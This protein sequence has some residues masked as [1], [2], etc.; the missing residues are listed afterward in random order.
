MKKFL[1]LTALSVGVLSVSMP[2]VVNAALKKSQAQESSGFLKKVFR[3]KKA[4]GTTKST[5]EQSAT[6]MAPND[7]AASEG[8][9]NGT[10]DSTVEPSAP[11]IAP[12]DAAAPATKT[13]GYTLDR[14]DMGKHVILLVTQNTRDTKELKSLIGD[15]N[16]AQSA[17][18]VKQKQKIKTFRSRAMPIDLKDARNVVS[19]SNNVLKG[20]GKNLKTI[21][22]KTFVKEGTSEDVLKNMLKDLEDE[23]ASLKAQI[24]LLQEA[25]ES[26]KSDDQIQKA[27]KEHLSDLDFVADLR[28]EAL[29]ALSLTVKNA[30]LGLISLRS[31][32]KGKDGKLAED[33]FIK[34]ELNWAEVA[35]EYWYFMD[36][37]FTIDK[38]LSP[39]KKDKQLEKLHRLSKVI[40]S[41]SRSGSKIGTEMS[42]ILKQLNKL[43]TREKTTSKSGPKK[44]RIPQLL[45]ILNSS[46]EGTTQASSPAQPPIRG[47]ELGTS[48]NEEEE[49]DADE[50]RSSSKKAAPPAM[51][52][53]PVRIVVRQ[54]KVGDGTSSP[55]EKA[56]RTLFSPRTFS[57]LRKKS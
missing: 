29:V 5:V 24:S 36:N 30:E 11:P 19:S 28:E 17:A 22:E 25:L 35:K 8:A 44:A 46:A 2:S 9:T 23:S 51:G 40:K 32:P 34:E 48:N 56:A 47:L 10:T 55:R 42:E 49:D 15:L 4:R 54:Y 57:F 43:T 52:V 37:A 13:E 1:L 18:Q 16:K 31:R 20:A 21:E 33:Q 26:F 27:V 12:N 7:A 50:D 39:D 41:M 53:V 14:K 6:P 3:S 38:T 45:K